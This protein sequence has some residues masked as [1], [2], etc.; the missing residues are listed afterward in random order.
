MLFLNP[1]LLLA[2][3]GVLIPVI[4][5]LLRRQAAKPV[6]WGAMRF[7]M[8]TLSERR[9]RMEWEDLLLMAARCLL[10]ALAALAIARPFV[11]PDSRLPWSLLLPLILV[12]IAVFGGSFVAGKRQT[13]GILRA[14]AIIMLLGIAA[15]I[16]F[17]HSLNLR[18]FETSGRRDLAIV[19]DASSSMTRETADGKLF[20]LARE[21]ARRIIS[22]A[23]RGTSFALIAGGPAPQ[24]MSD[25]PLSHRADVLELLGEMKPLGG[26]FRAHEAL[27]VASLVL[28]EGVHANKQIV[29][30]TDGQRH[31]WRFGD[32]GA[33]TSL[34]EAWNSL[35]D[36]PKLLLRR[37]QTPD[38]LRN[39]GIAGITSARTLIGTDRPTRIKVQVENTGSEA[40]APGGVTL[41]I[42][43]KPAGREA[44]G[45]L[46]PGQSETV[47]FLHRFAQPGP[48]VVTARLDRADE[49]PDDNRADLVVAP[50]KKLP[51]LLVDGRP[52]GSF[53]ARAAGHTAL[54]LAPAGALLRGSSAG[55][56]FLMDPKVVSASRLTEDLI[57]EAEVVVLA[58]VPRLPTALADT[59]AGRLANGTGL[60]VITGP[61]TEPTFYN[62]WSGIDG[63]VLPLEIGSE[64]VDEDGVSPSPATFQHESLELFRDEAKS[65]LGKAVIRRWRTASERP[66]RGVMGAAF[67]NGDPFVAGRIYG[68]GRCLVAS[69]AFDGRS[70]QLPGRTSFVPLVHE[71]VSWT[72]GG[73]IDLNVEASWSPSVALGPASGGGLAAQY[74]KKQPGKNGRSMQRIDPAI[75]FDWG[76]K[77]PW[78]NIPPN[79]FGATWTGRLVPP[80]DGEYLFEAEVDDRMSLRIAGR[81]VLET[82][83]HEPR[84]GRT[85]LTG[86]S[87]VQVEIRYEED[88]GDAFCRLYWTPPGGVRSLIPPSAWQ[89]IGEQKAGEEFSAID[90]LGKRRAAFV[91]LGR[92]GRELRIDGVAAP[93][94]YQVELPDSLREEIGGLAKDAPLPLVVTHDIRESRREPM[95]G[96]DL[97]ELRSHVDTL[98]PPS[99]D[100]VLAVLSGRGY[101]KEITRVV[102]IAALALLVLESLLARWVSK[103]RRAGEELEIDFGD[104]GPIPFGK[105]G[106][107]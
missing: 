17:E 2:A 68:R 25:T 35:P 100:E 86:G 77:G 39:A 16:F 103:S 70:G 80:F 73:G 42:A 79:N 23:P 8:D 58:D 10:L 32:A 12:A 22:E 33:W 24:R 66:G 102:A 97:T 98:E 105:G 34:E 87:P 99:A 44:L 38:E 6:D 91:N 5:H 13:R 37:L 75:N 76:Q 107:R 69:C 92:R 48:Q 1:W 29:V 18:R 51:V 57:E 52:T 3:A 41:E 88:D 19:I 28:A 55:D 78:K 95:T 11:P 94:L 106:P 49:L 7:L 67:S 72:A 61:S 27:G 64:A 101:G 84:T 40:V 54:A 96:D 85:N 63:P 74:Y 43:G 4:V 36:K 45:L 21:E 62:S 30:L 26:T 60:L 65:D 50:R 93:G 14:L 83:L 53:L 81:T 15:M 104:Q 56:K 89:P 31:G 71:L 9:R 90:P 59:I 46:I 47:E 82:S 20:E